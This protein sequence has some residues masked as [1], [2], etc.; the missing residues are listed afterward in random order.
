MDSCEFETPSGYVCRLSWQNWVIKCSLERYRPSNMKKRHVTIDSTMSVPDMISYTFQETTSR[1]RVGCSVSKK[2]RKQSR[3][4]K[5]YKK[6]ARMFEK[7]ELSASSSHLLDREVV[8]PLNLEN[9][10]NFSINLFEAAIRLQDKGVQYNNTKFPAIVIKFRRPSSAVLVFSTGSIICTGAK[11]ELTATYLVNYMV[12]LLR[13]RMYPSLR[14][15]PGTWSIEN[16]VADTHVKNK[17]DV[18]GF[19]KKYA[20]NCNYEPKIFSAATYRKKIIDSSGEGKKI[21]ILI[22]NSG[23]IV[24]TGA[25]NKQ[26]II[27]AFHGCLSELSPFIEK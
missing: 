7:G 27:S 18:Y 25:K 4:T 1:K 13:V 19:S 17:I 5:K 15:K 9:K 10:T 8:D 20:E 16:V 22:F 26:E 11:D 6:H 23:K 3:S 2:A 24:F 14:I 12:G 21:A